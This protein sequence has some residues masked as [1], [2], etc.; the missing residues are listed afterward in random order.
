VSTGDGF[1]V[2]ALAQTFRDGHVVNGHAHSWGQLTY[3]RTGIMHVTTGGRVWFVAPTRAIWIPPR[4]MH[5]LAFRGDVAF[6]TLYVAPERAG[7]VLRDIEA[8][9]VNTLLQELILHIAT[10]GM[11]DPRRPDHDRLAG[12]L[13]DLIANAR[14]DDLW[15]PLPTDPRA[16]RLAGHL[17]A[18]PTDKADLES[19]AADTGAS[20][21]TLQRCFVTETGLTIEQWRQK[22]RLVHSS[23]ELA[24]GASVTA[25]ALGCGYDSTS[26]YI[27]AFR[28]QF[29]V[30]PGRFARGERG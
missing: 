19:L 23:A 6:R 3:A 1:D 15:L 5:T 21:R 11:L 30:T 20:L 16:Q 10:I 28:A 26:A 27:A 29:G 24:S 17:R 14:G 12:V 22:A 2:R 4:T 8:L 7:A 13:M 25:A 9:R 18:Q